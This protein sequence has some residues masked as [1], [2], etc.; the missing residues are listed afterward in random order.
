MKKILKDKR[1]IVIF[2]VIIL[3]LLFLN[4]NQRMVLLSKLRGQQQELT[5]EYA[6]L[7]ATRSALETEIAYAKSD[8]AVEE[9]ARQEAGM[10]Q[11]GDVPIILLPPENPIPTPTSQPTAVVDR[12][13]NWEIWWE[14]FFGQ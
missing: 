14:L 11:E 5:Q 4:F 9:W 12:V 8:D 3:V 2:A 7:E 1:F 10:V 13:K 6:Q